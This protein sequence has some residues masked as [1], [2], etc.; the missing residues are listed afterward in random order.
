M[1]LIEEIR[2]SL[3]EILF[4]KQF[5]HLKSHVNCPGIEPQLR[6]V[7]GRFVSASALNNYEDSLCTLI[8]NTNTKLKRLTE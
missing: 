2:I 6:G 1:I 3:K 7:K 8:V 4:H 5:I